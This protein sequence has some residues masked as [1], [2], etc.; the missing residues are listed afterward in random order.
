MLKLI[1]PSGPR[2]LSVS[3]EAYSYREWSF[4][5]TMELLFSRVNFPEMVLP[6][7]TLSRE[8]G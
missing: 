3:M 2:H 1:E 4:R 8:T 6:V 5:E 7:S